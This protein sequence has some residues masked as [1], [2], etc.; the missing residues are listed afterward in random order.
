MKK[1][2]TLLC[3]A[4]LWQPN[5]AA[6]NTSE[7]PDPAFAPLLLLDLGDHGQAGWYRVRGSFR[8]GHNMIWSSEAQGIPGYTTLGIFTRNTLTDLK[9][10]ET[11]MRVGADLL[12]A[13]NEEDG[14]PPGRGDSYAL[15]Q[16]KWVK[17]GEPTGAEATPQTAGETKRL[18]IYTSSGAKGSGRIGFEATIWAAGKPQ[19]SRFTLTVW[20]N[21]PQAEITAYKG[22][23]SGVPALIREGDLEPLG[24]ART[25]QP[26]ERSTGRTSLGASLGASAVTD[27]RYTFRAEAPTQ[28]AGYATRSA[29]VISNYFF[30]TGLPAPA[31]IMM[32]TDDEGGLIG[33]G[34]GITG[35]LPPD[36]YTLHVNSSGVR[37]SLASDG[38]TGRDSLAAGTVNHFVVFSRAEIPPLD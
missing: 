1:V 16:S 25:Y 31:S 21:D 17:E 23:T 32:L 19:L 9:T 35:E 20:T 7:S 27:G 12:E 8:R 11:I 24:A 15:V 37:A 6:A 3:L 2:I 5:A 28:V 18:S 13:G 4:A 33:G 30:G 36:G 29:N 10:G 34:V 26:V 22:G 14:H 38:P